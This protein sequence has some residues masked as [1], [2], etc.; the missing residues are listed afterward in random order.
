MLFRSTAAPDAIIG[1]SD[2]GQLP[3]AS[4][5]D[6]WGYICTQAPNLI[7]TIQSEMAQLDTAAMEGFSVPFTQLTEPDRQ[8]VVDGLRAEQR[9]FMRGLATQT[10][11]CY[12]QQDLVLE[13]IGMEARPPFPQGYTVKQGD[14]SLL[15]PVR[16]R[17]K[18]YRDVVGDA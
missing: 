14:L 13:A 1:A 4:N 9:S 16:A 2:D 17:G 18:M 15:D 5:F 3:G 8:S 10:I 6:I 12:Y 7:T 11:A